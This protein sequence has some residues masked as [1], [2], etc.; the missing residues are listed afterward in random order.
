[1]HIFQILHN[2]G[3]FGYRLAPLC[4]YAV[5]CATLLIGIVVGLGCVCHCLHAFCRRKHIRWGM[6]A[7]AACFFPFLYLTLP[8]VLAKICFARGY[9]RYLSGDI[10][11][12]IGLY[13]QATRLD[14]AF[15][16]PLQGFCAICA[17]LPD[18]DPLISEVAVL[19]Q[20]SSQPALCATLARRLTSAGRTREAAYLY[21][22]AYRLSGRADYALERIARLIEMGDHVMAAAELSRL[23]SVG[24]ASEVWGEHQYLTA[25]IAAKNRSLSR[26]ISAIEHA[27]EAEP[28][29]PQYRVTFGD[30]LL[31]SGES[32]KGLR[33]LEIALQMRH[34]LPYAYRILG[35]YYYRR[36]DRTRL[37]ENLEKAIYYDNLYSSGWVMLEQN[38]LKSP[39]PLEKVQPFLRVEA[40][41]HPAETVLPCQVGETIRVVLE[42]SR[43]AAGTDLSKL[44]LA[45]LEPYGFGVEARILG[46]TINYDSERRERLQVTLDLLARRPSEVNSGKPWIV[47]VI[48]CDSV[49]GTYSDHPINV[50]VRADPR[51]EGRILL[52]ITQDHEQTSG[53]GLAEKGSRPAQV[54]PREAKIELVDKLQLAEWIANNNRITWSHVVDIGSSLL[55]LSWAQHTPFSPEW[56]RLFPEL[57]TAL[58]N[59]IAHGHDVQLHIHG[60]NVPG[61]RFSRQYYDEPT[62]TIRFAHDAS[63]P[64]DATG[65]HRAWAQNYEEYGNWRDSETRLG[66]LFKGVSLLEGELH[67]TDPNY[68]A[69][70]FR[71]GEYEFGSTKASV[72]ASIQALRSNQ[73][74]GDSDAHEGSPFGRDFKFHKRIGR[75]VYLSSVDSIQDR[76]ASLLDVGVLELVPVPEPL[77]H[78]HLSPVSEIGGI[79]ENYQQCLNGEKVKSGLF[80][81]LEM[82]HLNSANA[83]TQWD[84]LDPNFGDWSRMNHQFG[85]IKTVCPKLEPV[86]ISEAVKTYI[87]LYTPDLLGLRTG[88]RKRSEYEYDYEIRM[89]GKD[90]Y[91]SPARPHFVTVKPPSYFV[92]RIARLEIRQGKEPVAFWDSVNDYRDLPFRVTSTSGYTMHVTL[93]N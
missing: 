38:R 89:L 15:L 75:N 62:R 12:A 33:Q 47:N 65:S 80:L 34:D 61:N 22:E 77:G 60:Y 51:E 56:N 6:V 29:R 23:D 55:R 43:S 25:L 57:S 27:T 30:I 13:R 52:A 59:S 8:Q 40:L 44:S 39:V 84:N 28:A 36:M 90:I 18:D 53:G 68:R 5:Q 87:D 50:L 49:S 91:A 58:R 85:K 24:R 26:A 45:A 21:S 7:V 63:R 92:G 9:E 78:D 67:E 32:E 3:V 35:E 2:T 79:R 88:E 74:L 86:T 10:G 17:E 83:R 41:Q 66:S 4:V 16:L 37:V 42:Y 93:N 81:I 82:Y 48:L 11:A 76:A 71:A 20:R 46:K 73:I 69:L 54:S 70:F 31:R 72:A 14:H 64:G 1:M 19:V